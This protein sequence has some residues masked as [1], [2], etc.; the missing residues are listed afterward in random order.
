VSKV[1]LVGLF[2]IEWKTPHHDWWLNFSIVG[3]PKERKQV[4]LG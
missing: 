4:M 2:K 1:G 3:K